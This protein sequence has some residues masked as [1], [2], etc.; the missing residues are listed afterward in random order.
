MFT[1][2]GPAPHVFSSENVY[3]LPGKIEISRVRHFQELER[4]ETGRRILHRFMVR[5]HWRR[6]V[7]NWTDQRMRWIE[8]Y[9]KGPDIAAVIEREYRLK[10]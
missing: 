6:P 1:G 7:A 5:G 10:P 4:V 3:F 2:P 9:W 8:P